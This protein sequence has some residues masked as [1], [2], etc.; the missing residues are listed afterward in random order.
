MEMVTLTID[1]Q[2]VRVP[3]G[4]TVL[5]AAQQAGI[6]IP[7]LCYLKEINKIGACRVCLVEVKGARGLQASCVYPVAEGM[8]VKTNTPVIREARKAVV[9]LILSNHPMECLTCNRST[10]C[11]LQALAKKLGIKDIRFKGANTAFEPDL[12]SPSIERIPEKCILCRRCV[13]VCNQVQG[14]GVLGLTERGFESL[15]APPFHRTLNEVNCTF[16]GQCIN[17][18]PVGALREKDHTQRVWEAL[19]DPDK[20]VIV[21]TAPAVRVALGEEFGYPIGT[22]VTKKMVAALRRLGFD[23]V[24]DTDF[25][26]DLT[27]LEEGSELLE[28]VKE[29]GKLPLITSCSPGW[30]KY[31]EHHYPEFLDN[32]STAKSPQQMFGALAKTYYAEKAGINPAKIFSVSVMPCTAKKFECSRPELQDSGFPDVDAVLTTRELAD[33]IKEAGI[34]FRSLPEEEYDLPMGITTG[35]G[36]IFG[37]T[38][39]VMEAALRTVYEFVTGKTLEKVDFVAVRGIEGIKE[40]SIEIPPLGTV[41]VAVAHGL[42]NARKLL[43]K[44]KAGEADYHFIEIMACPGGCVGGGGQPIVSAPERMKLSEDYRVL[45]ARA[46]YQEDREM[47]L[48]KSHDNPAVKA[49]YEEYLGKPLSHKSHHLL[50]T[51][52][53][54]RPKYVALMAQE[55]CY[56]EKEAACCEEKE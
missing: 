48:R 49:L 5:E 39:G 34:D 1:G 18:C 20:H 14:V 28:R 51:H 36:L 31:C 25:T 3:A 24:F 50:H 9:E 10:N 21:Q 13:A 55:E 23:K 44:V 47:P 11:E 35:A 40:A 52:Y 7:T 27:I 46:I 2:V 12:S 19:N 41:K 26:A 33:M 6:D 16:C 8:E 45:R 17:V 32:L 43:E 29:G 42:N 30:V 4:T 56:S 54:K 37:A 15:V 38:G 53:I 22:S